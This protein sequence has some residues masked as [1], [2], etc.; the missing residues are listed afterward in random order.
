MTLSTRLAYSASIARQCLA[1]EGSAT[2]PARDGA[3]ADAPE[4]EARMDDPHCPYAAPLM[5]IAA[6]LM[7]VAGAAALAT[8]TAI[9]GLL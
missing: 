6:A 2:G 1:Q 3:D 7:T 5:S 9:A 8:L 4:P